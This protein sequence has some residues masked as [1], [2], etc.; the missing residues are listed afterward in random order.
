MNKL[1]FKDLNSRNAINLQSLLKVN[2]SKIMDSDA[3]YKSPFADTEN[4]VRSVQRKQEKEPE[5]ILEYNTIAHLE[6]YDDLVKS[7]LETNYQ[8]VRPIEVKF[9]QILTKYENPKISV[10]L[11]KRKKSKIVKVERVL[12]G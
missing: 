2:P 12:L 11:T 3:R 1:Y 7:G 9:D 10:K 6:T 5:N 4:I 8:E